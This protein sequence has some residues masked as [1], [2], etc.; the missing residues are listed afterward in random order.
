MKC[1]NCGKVI[2][3]A[4]LNVRPPSASVFCSIVCKMEWED[5]IKFMVKPKIKVEVKKATPKYYQIGYTFRKE[6]LV[7]LGDAKL[8]NTL[9]EAMD[10]IEE[11]YESLTEPDN[12]EIFIYEIK[13]I[14]KIIIPKNRYEVE[15]L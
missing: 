12:S 4:F 10:E 1:F 8:F 11:M 14:K 5:K 9:A 3:G 13:P 7:E 15:D 6:D 2:K